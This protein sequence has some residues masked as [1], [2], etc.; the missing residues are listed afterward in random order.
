M[1]VDRESYKLLLQKIVEVH[2]PD[3]SVAFELGSD[4]I[5]SQA[6]KEEQNANPKEH[7]RY[8]VDTGTA[9]TILNIVG[10]ALSGWKIILELRK[11]KK[12]AETDKLNNLQNLL[13]IMLT[14]KGIEQSK[15][16]A[17]AKK[18][19]KELEGKIKK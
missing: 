19:F 5:V 9:T 10:V 15:A 4:E 11:L 18:F 8:G 2:F 13:I 14:D 16:K 3:E 1:I 12:E 6:M 7:E 17:V